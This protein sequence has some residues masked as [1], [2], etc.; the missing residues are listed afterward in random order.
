MLNKLFS[1]RLSV[2][3]ECGVKFEF[4]AYEKKF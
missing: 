4:I 1:K 3:N 2:T